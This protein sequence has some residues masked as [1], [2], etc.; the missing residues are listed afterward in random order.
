MQLEP[1]KSNQ[2]KIIL[3]RETSFVSFLTLCLHFACSG[4]M[5]PEYALKGHVSDKSDVYSFGIVVLEVVHGKSNTTPRLDSEE[6]YF[7]D[8]VII[9]CSLW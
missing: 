8:W 3:L 6:L 9:L 1:C 7:V 5:A 4:Y 2:P